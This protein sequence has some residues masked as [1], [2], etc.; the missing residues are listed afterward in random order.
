MSR[1]RLHPEA[2]AE[3]LEALL[4]LEDEREGYADVFEAEVEAVIDRI[5]A[6][7]RSGALVRG[8]PRDIEA[9]AF[10][11]RRFRY[12]LMVVFEPTGPMI[13]AVAHQSRRPGYWYHRSK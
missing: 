4:L 10:P 11:L 6:F 13:C 12:S 1:P 8:F 3:Y 5:I 7:P 2:Q 9:R